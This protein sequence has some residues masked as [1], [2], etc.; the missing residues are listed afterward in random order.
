MNN[1][2][3]KDIGFSSTNSNSAVNSNNKNSNI[4]SLELSEDLRNEGIVTSFIINKKFNSLI[5]SLSDSYGKKTIVCPIYLDW[6]KT[7]ETFSK[8]LKNKGVKKEHIANLGDVL[9]NNFEKIIGLD[10]AGDRSHSSNEDED[11]IKRQRPLKE[12]DIRKYTGN[13]NLQLHESIVVKDESTFVRLEDDDMRPFYVTKIERPNK[14]L[15]PA[16]NIDTQNPLPYIF[17]SAEEL[18]E[19]LK[20]ARNETFDT[21]LSKVKSIYKIY[22]NTE[23]HYITI[24]A[25]DTIYSYFQDKFPTVHYNI[26]VGDNGSGKNSALL[27][28]KYLGYRVFY[29]TAASAPNYFTF[30]GEIEECQGTIAEDEADDIG[31]DKEKKRILK[32]GYASGGSIPK[33]DLSNGRTQGSYLTYCMK[34]FAMEELPD[35][36]KIKGILDRSFVYKFVTGEVPY[37]IKDVIKYSGD[38]K[39]K[40]LHDELIDIRKLLLAFRLIHYNDVI[41]DVN[42]NIKHR[43]EEL[44][45]P[46]LR[47]FNSLG[48]APLAIEEIRVALSKFIEERNALKKNSIESKLY[49]VI[50]NLVRRRQEGQE[51]EEKEEYQNLE[52]YSFYNEQ[53][54]DEAK[55]VMNGQDIPYQTQSFYTVDYGAISH[56]AITGLYKSK[57]KA[58][59]FKIGSGI[60][61][62]RG[63]KFSKEVLD[64]I[65]IYYNVPDEIKIL[66]GDP[67]NDNAKNQRQYDEEQDEES[68]NHNNIEES[69]GATHATD[70]TH[71][72]SRQ[73][74]KEDILKDSINKTSEND[75]ASTTQDISKSYNS[76]LDNYTIIK[77]EN[78]NDIDDTPLL[79]SKCVASVA[80]VAESNDNSNNRSKR[81]N[82]ADEVGLPEIPC[83]FSCGYKDCIDF[84]LSLHYLECHKPELFALPIGKGS[85][86]DRADYAVAISKKRLAESFSDDEEEE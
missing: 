41:A 17:A 51:T 77:T 5:L 79:S 57:F 36:K 55:N 2:S 20:R 72:N 44:T 76:S 73:W 86:E 25:A 27:V 28:Y 11:N 78:N 59:P 54:W 13:G 34:W 53:I 84:D 8:R 14:I 46:L 63:L 85:M 30:L 81:H 50:N 16:D 38:A 62:K 1:T 35:Y 31:Y 66:K 61:T 23:E 9:D 71:Y 12:F 3:D 21:F 70:A 18:E 40:P 74:L 65:A 39:F 56:K 82:K 60:E 49:E 22:V 24:L 32:T 7:I 68:Q 42:L 33:V 10:G 69:K 29:V 43:S 37:N 45:K 58:E 83:L 64:R 19:Y 26:F 6:L 75:R 4:V 52:P 67:H 47:L 80:T 48:N 15:Y